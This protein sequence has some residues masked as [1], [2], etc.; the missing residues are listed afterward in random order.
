MAA[1]S[2]NDSSMDAPP[3]QL[4]TT[5]SVGVIKNVSRTVN[6]NCIEYLIM[7]ENKNNIKLKL[8]Y[9]VINSGHFGIKAFLENDDN[10]VCYIPEYDIKKLIGKDLQNCRYYDNIYE[11][12][13]NVAGVRLILHNLE[14][15]IEA[16]NDTSIWKYRHSLLIEC[17]G[18]SIQG[19]L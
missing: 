19:E 8:S 4:K 12:N 7:L 2:L 18:K 9:T 11:N 6:E 16:F 1:S 10:W 17:N 15:V 3:S 14:V 13:M 5:R